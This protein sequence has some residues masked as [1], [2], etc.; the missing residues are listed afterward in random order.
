[1]IWLCLVQTQKFENGL[2]AILR[3]SII[4]YIK[5][6]TY[7]TIYSQAVE[8][9]LKKSLAAFFMCLRKINFKNLEE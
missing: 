7:F 2:R 1:M 5:E 8:E 3:Y 6:G 4:M 9:L